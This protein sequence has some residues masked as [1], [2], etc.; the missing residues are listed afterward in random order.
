MILS[1]KSSYYVVLFLEA[2]LGTPGTLEEAFMEYIRDPP[3][4]KRRLRHGDDPEDRADTRGRSR[5][6]PA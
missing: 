2:L 4:F 5:Q 6:R 3:A 1:C